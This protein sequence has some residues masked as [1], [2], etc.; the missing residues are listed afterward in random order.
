MSR[1]K[2]NTLVLLSAAGVLILILAMSLPNLV[3]FGG[4][5]F[6]LGEPS[7]GSVGANGLMPGGSDLV[8]LLIHGLL[9]LFLI[10]VP[11][12]IVY[13]LVSAQG[14]RRLVAYLGRSGF[15]F[16]VAQYL[17]DH[18]LNQNKQQQPTP[19]ALAGNPDQKAGRRASS[20]Q[21]TR[22]PG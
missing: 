8:Q 12:Y 5:P 16:A 17:E 6:S 9:A 2:R 11:I 20:S 3:L 7:A 21:R 15:Y 4:E 14:R 19:A 10:M 1:T 13:S 22:P 18:P